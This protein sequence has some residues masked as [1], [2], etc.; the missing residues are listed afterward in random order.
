MSLGK[1]LALP[2]NLSRVRDQAAKDSAKA[3]WDP[4]GNRQRSF[5]ADAGV[6]DGGGDDPLGELLFGKVIN[7]YNSSVGPLR[8]ADVAEVPGRAV[9]AQDLR[10][11]K[12][13]RRGQH[14]KQVM[15][16][17]GIQDP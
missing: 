3:A 17:A 2:A 16:S 6:P 11:M 7:G 5:L 1:P 13:W 8:C 14:W 12:R 15:A 9:L 10:D 4:A